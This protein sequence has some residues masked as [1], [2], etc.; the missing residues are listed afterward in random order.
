MLVD[1]EMQWWMDFGVKVSP[2]GVVNVQ[3]RQSGTMRIFRDSL[4]TGPTA[5][6]H[7]DGPSSILPSMSGDG[8][9]LYLHLDGS[10]GGDLSRGLQHRAKIDN[11][12]R[13]N[14]NECT[15]VLWIHYRVMEH[16]LNYCL[17]SN[18][19]AATTVV[20]TIHT[21]GLDDFLIHSTTKQQ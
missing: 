5:D 14:T 15:C 21:M 13:R 6:H 12:V 2:W 10:T 9:I 20:P 7:T 11:V 18:N 8:V 3:I 19:S 17:I 1:F 4:V 16:M